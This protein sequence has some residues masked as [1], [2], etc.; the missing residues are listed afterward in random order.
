MNYKKEY[1][2]GV[3]EV[4]AEIGGRGETELVFIAKRRKLIAF[5]CCKISSVSRKSRTFVAEITLLKQQLWHYQ[6]KKPRL[7]TAMMQDVSL[8]QWNIRVPFLR[9]K[10]Y[11]QRMHS[12][13]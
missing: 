1:D 7:S 13:K 2:G 5:S 8:M 12:T 9:M 10:C 11:A 4:A 3:L 6:S